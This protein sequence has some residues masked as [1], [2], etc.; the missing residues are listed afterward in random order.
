MNANGKLAICLPTL[1][2]HRDRL[3]AAQIIAVIDAAADAGFGGVQLWAAYVGWAAAGG[4][5][6]PELFNYHRERGLEIEA[7]EFFSE[8][9]TTDLQYVSD[10]VMPVLDVAARAGASGIIAVTLATDLPPLS[11]AS[12]G[13]RHA[14]DLAA[15]QGLRISFEFLPWTAIPT[16]A[17]ALELFEAVDRGN[18][19]LVFDTWHWFRQPGGP[20]LDLLRSIPPE[21]VHLL[22]LND[23]PADAAEDLLAET[24]TARLLPGDGAID[25]LGALSVLAEIG[26]SPLVV[27]EVFSSPLA[28]L[29]PAEFARRQFHAT[30]KILDRH[31]IRTTNSQDQGLVDQSSPP[32][33]SKP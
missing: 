26:A 25:I 29:G 17:S 18:L 15:E 5:P 33:R 24:G 13:L 9:A 22:Q 6:A 16:L 31:G 20:D 11:V 1:V 7:V 19:G 30:A 14:C 8:W 4:V 2:P 27:S 3:D 10:A 21:R 28:L 32:L 12:V 23:A